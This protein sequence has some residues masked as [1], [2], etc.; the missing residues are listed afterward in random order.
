MGGGKLKPPLF[1]AVSFVLI[2]NCYTFAKYNRT[3]L[4]KLWT[5]HN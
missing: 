1:Y 3:N 5:I 4:G 2:R